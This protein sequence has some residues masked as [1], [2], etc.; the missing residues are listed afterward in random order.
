MT[1][2]PEQASAQEAVFP[3]PEAKRFWLWQAVTWL[4]PVALAA[5]AFVVIK[6]ELQAHS[7]ADVAAA[8]RGI[9]PHRVAWAFFFTAVTYVSLATYDMLA[10]IYG[11]KVLP[12]G[13]TAGIAT[14]SFAFGNAL[15]FNAITGGLMRIRLY[16]REGLNAFEAARI[17][18]FNLITFWVGL[19]VA[20]GMALSLGHLHWPPRAPHWL[21]SPQIAGLLLFAAVI[22][23]FAACWFWPGRRLLAKGAIRVPPIR[24]GLGQAVS[25]T[26]EWLASAAV[27]WALLPGDQV[28]FGGVLG[29]F[30]V[31][32]LL[33][34][35][36]AVPGGLGVF[37]V[38]AI[39]F[40]GHSL[41]TPRV[42]G[43]LLVYRMIYTFTPFLIALLAFVVGEWRY[44][45]KK[46]RLVKT[47]AS[48]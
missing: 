8:M 11:G 5:L 27:L 25:G 19:G 33:G 42:V 41:G 10:Q 9:A 44:R 12:Y 43:V 30:V 47:P 48:I 32:L 26:A 21:P 1:N 23:Y 14:L 6:R 13:R 35:I 38:S 3:P 28:S 34:L 29:I 37:E 45:K 18:A 36:S 2:K 20:G 16:G 4:I 22:A 15:G 31:S 24:L 7:F 17:S 39:F 46:R 40:L